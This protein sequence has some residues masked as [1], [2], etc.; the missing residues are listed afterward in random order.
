MF[1]SRNSSHQIYA[2]NLAAQVE[3]SLLPFNIVRGGIRIL[4]PL[5]EE[6]FS[7]HGCSRCVAHRQ[8]DLRPMSPVNVSSG[9][10][11]PPILANVGIGRCEPQQANEVL[12]YQH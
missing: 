2:G 1:T 5:V 10:P 8:P 3:Q 6:I 12:I 11:A 4:E 9:A 7:R